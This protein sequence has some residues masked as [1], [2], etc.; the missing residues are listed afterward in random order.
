[1]GSG[2]I[3]G[4]FIG[5]AVIALIDWSIPE[6]ENPHDYKGLDAPTAKRQ[7]MRALGIEIEKLRCYI[8]DNL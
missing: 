6:P 5:I 4:F 1:L 8:Q 7:R 3:S 2:W